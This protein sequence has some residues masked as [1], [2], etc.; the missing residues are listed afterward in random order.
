MSPFGFDK[1]RFR[2]LQLCRCLFEFLTAC[3][4][5]RDELN[6]AFMPFS[7]LKEFGLDSFEPGKRLIHLCAAY[8]TDLD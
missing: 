7:I 5:D 4:P 8:R 2:R 1:V 6:G 3:G